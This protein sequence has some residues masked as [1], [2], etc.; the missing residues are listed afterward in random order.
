VRVAALDDE[1]ADAIR[2]AGGQVV[3]HRCAEVVQVD[4]ETLDLQL[5]EQVFDRPREVSKV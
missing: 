5:V 2:G 4:E 3:S 1:A